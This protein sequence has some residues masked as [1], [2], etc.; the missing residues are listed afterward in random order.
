[1]PKRRVFISYHHEGEQTIVNDFIRNFSD[2]YDV[3]TDRSLD[4][5]ADSQ[6]V[7]YLNEVCRDAID[8]TSVTIVMIGQQT[9]NRKFVDWEIRYTLYRNHGLVAISRPNLD[10]SMA[11]L[12]ARLVD[13]IDSGY[14]KWY[15]YPSDASELEYMIDQAYA[16]EKARI[17]NSREKMSR[18]STT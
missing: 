17:V 4:R 1:M 10:S 9:G 5:A 2:R 13:N 3:F 6:D 7:E 15:E 14:A 16:S 12:P 8:G 18:N 11:S